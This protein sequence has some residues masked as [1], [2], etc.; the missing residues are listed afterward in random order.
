MDLE[1]PLGEFGS[2]LGASSV[3]EQTSPPGHLNV[4]PF[5][6][7]G[8]T[9]YLSILFVFVVIAAGPGTITIGL[10]LFILPGLLLIGSVTLL[11]YSIALLPAYF[12][13]RHLE[14]RLLA[15]AVAL[16]GVAAAVLSP[17]YVSEYWLR[18]LVASD[19]SNP[20]A[21]LR[22]RSFELPAPE[23]SSYWTNWRRPESRL[24]T[25]PPPCA[26][27]CQQ[28]LFKGNVD[29]V[30]V[31]GDSSEDPLAAG[32]IVITGGKAYHLPGG[33]SK[34]VIHP[35][36]LSG[37][38]SIQE[39]PVKRALNPAEFF[40]PK[41][42]RFRLQ[43][44]ET[45]P[46]TLTLIEGEFVRQVIG[47]RCLLEDTVES[48]DAEVV[49][50]MSKPPEVRMRESPESKRLMLAT[51]EVKT[52]PT[53]VTITERR[54]G[55]AI[56]VEVKTTLVARYATVPFYFHPVR[57]GGSEIPDF[58]LAVAMEPFPSSFADPFEMIG[59]RYG[60][61]IAETP[62]SARFSVPVTAEDRTAVDAILKQ[63]YGADGFIAMTPSRFIASFVDARLKSGQLNQDDIE[64]ID[65]LMKQRAFAVSIET[66]F[67]PA[68]YQALKPLLPEMFERIAYRADGQDRIVQSLNVI[69]DHFSA[70]DIDP[71]LPALCS[72]RKNADLRVC[73]KR[74]FRNR[75][76]K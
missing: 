55:R 64:L 71:Y 46:D 47:G 13:N 21:L 25:P 37:D 49:L 35:D 68:T 3:S 15:A 19:H 67:P 57:C 10:L 60:L 74:E 26:D 22:P 33:G 6:S 54:D 70:D 36:Q 65:A 5:V 1:P 30:F 75:P 51:S 16:Y 28:L 12:I 4:R 40:K 48:S 42:R 41:W 61:A 59:R 76:K 56:P 29:L 38:N 58:C 63:D 72:E 39:I 14:K 11:Y 18:S 17:H 50:S 34:R 23:G 20:P 27:L 8:L 44:R 7:R 9:I 73:Y 66:K 45:C 69:L 62:K 32:T 24:R 31:G 53:T 2:Q 43:H 52:G